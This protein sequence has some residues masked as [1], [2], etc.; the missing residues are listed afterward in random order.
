M[1]V[2]LPPSESKAHWWTKKTERLSYPLPKPLDIALGATAKDLKCIGKRLQ[3][4]QQLNQIIHEGPRMKAVERYNG[5]MFKALDYGTLSA[6]GKKRHDEH[7]VILSWMY[8]I[9]HPNDHIANYKL[10]IET[11]GLAQYRKQLVAEQLNT[12]ETELIVN[13]L[14][15]SYTA[16]IDRDNLHARVVHIEFMQK[17]KGMKKKLTHNVKSVKG[18]RLRQVCEG[19]GKKIDWKKCE[20]VYQV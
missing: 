19:R 12:I 7:V 14:S 11:K 6:K 2:L 10:P 15:W 13:C 4:A 3:E 16:M 8:G 18:R 5:V 1:I 17:E 20:S 9:V